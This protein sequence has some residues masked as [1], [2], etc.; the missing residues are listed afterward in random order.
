MH[1]IPLTGLARFVP[2]HGEKRLG[3][4]RTGFV[5]RLLPANEHAKD[6]KAAWSL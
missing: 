3:L 6:A 5:G 2:G 4:R 1:W